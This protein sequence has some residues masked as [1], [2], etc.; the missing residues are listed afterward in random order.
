MK[1]LSLALAVMIA[2]ARSLAGAEG[3]WP[4]E[5]RGMTLPKP[6]WVLVVPAQR[7]AD[8]TVSAWDRTGPWMRKWV[9]PRSAKGNLRTV[10]VTGDSEDARIVDGTQIDN[11]DTSALGRLA[12][13]YGAPAVAVVLEGTEGEA[14]VAVWKPGHGAAWDMTHP[15]EDAREGSLRLIGELFS[16]QRKPRFQITGVRTVAGVEQYRLS[17]GDA[18]LLDRLGEMPGIKV[19]ETLDGDD[20]RPSAVVTVTDGR[21]IEDVLGGWVA[22]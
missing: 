2:P 10:A 19:V 21:R 11:M 4:P 14:A 3:Y 1:R 18:S 7:G 22:R 6:A 8:G 9:V 15:G 20:D 16:G 17:A 13:K 12:S 5:A